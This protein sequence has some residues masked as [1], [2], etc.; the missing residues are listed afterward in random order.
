M[1]TEEVKAGKET[2]RKPGKI[3][4]AKKDSCMHLFREPGVNVSEEDGPTFCVVRLHPYVPRQR[5][6]HLPAFLEQR[7]HILLRYFK[8]LSVRLAGTRT[9]TSRKTGSEHE[10]KALSRGWT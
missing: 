8:A 3:S 5:T 10:T 2:S 9:T 1:F 6:N 4:G 7:Q